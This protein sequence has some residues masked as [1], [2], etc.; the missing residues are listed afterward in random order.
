M[1]HATALTSSFRY[2]TFSTGWCIAWCVCLL[3]TPQLLGWYTKLYCVVTEA[4]K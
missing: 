1:G 4:H 2:K 3:L